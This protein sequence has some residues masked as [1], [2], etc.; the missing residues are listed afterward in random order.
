[1]ILPRSSI[2]TSTSW[3]R[4]ARRRSRRWRRRSKRQGKRQKSKV[5]RQKCFDPRSVA[6]DD[7]RVAANR[8]NCARQNAPLH[9]CL[10]TFDLP[11]TL[12]SLLLVHNVSHGLIANEVSDVF[13]EYADSPCMGA[14]RVAGHVRRHYHV[15]E[16]P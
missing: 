2:L 11:L 3:P 14:G 4:S 15:R 1:M 13:L 16:L 5:K 8:F 6:P 7:C 12:V 10:L 9:F